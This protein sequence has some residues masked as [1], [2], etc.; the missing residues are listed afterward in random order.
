MTN[1][2]TNSVLPGGDPFAARSVST[3]SDPSAATKDM[4]LRLLVSQ[5]KNQDP[6]NPADGTQFVAQLAQFSQLEQ[7]L[8][9]ST[10]LQ[11][12][13][14][15]LDKLTQSADGGSSTAATGN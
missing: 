9:M 14:K 3:A 10:D 15:D 6:L 13:R 5:I 7:T 1:S 12:I 8:S 4:F 11:A 2:V